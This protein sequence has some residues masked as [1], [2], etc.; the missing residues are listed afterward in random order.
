MYLVRTYGYS[1]LLLGD[2]FAILSL[3]GDDNIHLHLLCYSVKDTQF[4]QGDVFS[5]TVVLTY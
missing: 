3:R 2:N 4:I 1:I 5:Q